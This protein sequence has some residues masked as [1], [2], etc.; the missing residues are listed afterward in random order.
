MTPPRRLPA[1]VAALVT[2]ALGAAAGSGLGWSLA[3]FG[4]AL[5]D[6]AGP[7][8]P[9]PAPRVT[10][11]A[12]PP[13]TVQRQA[14]P[15]VPEA[16][17]VTVAFSGDMLTHMPVNA[18]AAAGGDYDFSPLLAGTDSWIAGADLAICQME[19]PL[20]APGRGPSG[21]PIFAAPDALV[22][23]M[24]EA[25]W[26]GCATASNHAVD[27]GWEGIVHTIETLTAHGLGYAGT[28]LT[29]ADS[30]A[31]QLYRLSAAGQTLTIAHIAATYGTNGLPLPAAQPWSVNTPI[32]TARI[33]AQ[34]EAARAGGADVVLASVHAG[35]E[36]RTSPTAEQVEIVARLAASGQI[37]AV[38]GG[39]PHVAEP[40]ELVPG[41]VHGDGMW[42]IYSLGNF[43]SNQTD[44][45]TGP[46]TDTGVVAFVTI[47]KDAAG[48]RVDGMTWAGVTVD[49]AH[50]HRVHMLEDAAGGE[51]GQLGAAAV[52]LR[53]D[54]LRAIMGSAPEQLS[55][56]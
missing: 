49:S 8:S 24:A 34:A 27:Q 7:S 43:I 23:D 55:P 54:R 45:V 35:V 20:A 33:V 5:P 4:T 19:V 21:Y 38:I 6:A 51:L 31:P 40:M 9:P 41:G 14:P 42:V 47:T 16:M 52:A 12:T 28:A 26:D 17:T 13:V 15:A 1:P 48:A 46:N 56:P 50:G 37:D 25:G 11:T 10:V 32:D 44:A 3:T 22:R 36:Y 39:H 30:Q 18:S 2:I 53:H 29:A